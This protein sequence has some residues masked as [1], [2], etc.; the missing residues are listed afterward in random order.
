MKIII[1]IDPGANG[2]LCILR[3]GEPRIL[4]VDEDNIIPILRLYAEQ[5]EVRAFIERIDCRKRYRGKCN[6]NSLRSISENYGYW[7]GILAGI[8]IVKELVESSTFETVCGCKLKA[9]DYARQKQANWE[10][11]Q[12]LYPQIKICKYAADAVLIAHYGTMRT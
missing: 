1:G 12:A 11:A 4:R 2:A 3:N 9:Y 8:G 10:K 6:I 5:G 7:R